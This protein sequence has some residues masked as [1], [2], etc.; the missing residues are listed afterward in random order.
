MFTVLD[1]PGAIEP[2]V[3]FKGK[4]YR[5]GDIM[6]KAEDLSTALCN[7]GSAIPSR[8]ALLLGNHPL[9]FS[10]FFSNAK[11]NIASV[12]LS[13]HLK[14][15]E[16]Q[17]YLTTTRSSILIADET[18]RSLVEELDLPKE[19]IFES[20]DQA[21]GTALVYRFKTLPEEV[22]NHRGD[23][24]LQMTSGVHG[25]SKIVPRGYD[26]LR[27][28]VGN[29]SRAIDL[30]PDDTVV[31]A[32]PLFHTYGFMNGLLMP[33]LTG[34]RIV[35]MERFTPGDFLSIVRLY[36]PTIFVGV[37]FMYSMLVQGYLPDDADFSSLRICFSAGG[38]V[39]SELYDKF[40]GRFG[41]HINQQYGSTETGVMTLNL[42]ADLTPFDCV[43]K[44]VPGRSMKVVDGDGNE[45]GQGALGEIVI[46]SGGTTLGYHDNDELTRAAFRD[47]WYHTGDLG[48]FDAAGNLTVTARKSAFINVAGLKVDPFEV[49]SVLTSNPK[50]KECA[51][52]GVPHASCGEMIKAFV[53]LL[54]E[55]KSHDIAMYCKGQLADYKVPREFV[56]VEQLPM[57]PTGK[58]LKKYLLS[59]VS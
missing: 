5:H 28:E 2:V 13:T 3:I 54:D 25:Q 39:S 31:C 47:G 22:W 36:R 15:Y 10:A 51:V 20:A 17:N 42:S 53:V 11:N 1:K 23:L 37:P 48:Y 27:D 41:L 50:V 45:L 46:K 24:T 49:E 34:S 19:L 44:P 57:S 43:G 56:F 8:V 29:F 16:I 4:E 58:V 9:L 35:L 33:Y 30:R 59:E 32:A 21:F 12:L 6:S 38:K 7:S 55:V 18:S 52:V 14:K 40:R 26:S